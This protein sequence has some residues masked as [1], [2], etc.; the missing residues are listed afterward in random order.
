MSK[1]TPPSRL[2]QI[3]GFLDRSGYEGATLHPLPG[4]A[5]FRRYVR[6]QRGDKTAML[7]D[8]PPQREDVRSYIAIADYL[9]RS[10]YSAPEIF[11]QHPAVG[12]LLLEDLGDDS[13]TSMLKADAEGGTREQALYASAIDVLAEWHDRKRRFADP[14][15][16]VLPEYDTARLMQEVMLFADWFLPQALGKQEAAVLHMEYA[17][18]WREA[19]AGTPLSVDCWV[20][21]DYHAD[22]LMWLPLRRGTKRV[23]L[24]DFQDGVYGDAAYDLVSLLEDARRD[25]SP[26]LAEAML[27]RYLD[28]SGDDRER[29]FAAYAVLGAQRNSKIVGI[30]SRLA[31]RDGK[32]AYLRFL[33]RV[34]RHLERDLAHPALSSLKAWLDRH[35][36]ASQRGVIALR[37]TSQDLALTA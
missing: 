1:Q 16:L 11:A 7:M 10:G 31:A 22:N 9:R 37:H 29:F 27:A 18:L 20:H 28:V 34:W 4:D 6:V 19:L 2:E 14:R 12:L 26:K 24:L 17:G 33:P 25:V 15:A 32:F 13:Y 8:A 5:S 35:I 21:R 30:F 23:G 36:P 3:T